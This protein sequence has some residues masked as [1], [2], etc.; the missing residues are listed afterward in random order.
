MSYATT[1]FPRLT[2]HPDGVRIIALSAAI[3]LNLAMLLVAMRPLSANLIR[4]I[5]P[6]SVTLTWHSPP[7]AVPPPP[8]LPQLQPLQKTVPQITPT[9]PVKTIAAVEPSTF[10]KPMPAVA[11]VPTVS[12][13]ITAPVVAPVS[14]APAETTLAYLQAPAPIYPTQARRMHMQGTV[15]LRVRVDA[16]GH[17]LDVQVESSSGY[18]V[19]DR[20]ARLQVLQHWRFQAAE[21]DGHAVS[22][23]A[24]VPINFNLRNR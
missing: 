6:P 5:P 4:L 19:L 18:P 23:W 8:A 3:G 12:H 15:V 11:I 21:V 2:A 10:S 16:S 22:A 1:A 13:A 9:V 17:P 14:T 20:A 7:P 24:R